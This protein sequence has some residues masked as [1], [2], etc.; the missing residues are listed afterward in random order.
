[1]RD[2][3][4]IGGGLAG[5]SL[6]AAV[7]RAGH[8][9]LLVERRQL[10]R[11]KV[12]GEF[13]SPDAILSLR[14]LGL[15]QAVQRLGPVPI[16]SARL[17]SRAGLGLT[18]PL[19]AV[20]WG[21][22]R[23]SLDQAMLAEA[24]AAGAE[25]QAGVSASHLLPEEGG[26]RVAV[27]GTWVRSRLVVG[28]WGRQTT[29]ALR[30]HQP[31]PRHRSWVGLKAHLAATA[32]GDQVELYFV[33]GGYLG[34]A[35]VNGG[36]VNCSALVSQ[37]AFRR[38]GSSL[39]AFLESARRQ[40]PALAQRLAGARP[41]PATEAAVACV[42]TAQPPIPWSGSLPLLG[43]AAAMIPPLAGDGMAMA[44]RTAELNLPW[45]LE[46]LAG[47]LTL[48]HWAERYCQA[49]QAE[50]ARRLRTARWIQAA[51]MRPLLGDGLILLGHLLPTMAIRLVH[52]TRGA[53]TAH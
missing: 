24:R 19:P 38:A 1:M 53:V 15:L 11:H 28:A 45:V 37:E 2:L 4:V 17:T 49:Y 33:D 50:F 35:P 48:G 47:R 52:A 8:D 30:A 7:A 36:R 51:L 44:L 26:F 41:V 16:R 14:R 10:P 12:C 39:A 23:Y 6:A 22:S 5:A 21:I 40:S 31:P 43:D 20:A 18:V 32:Q 25:V 9:V 27:G 46:H 42:D 29:P 3:I 34:L 13:L